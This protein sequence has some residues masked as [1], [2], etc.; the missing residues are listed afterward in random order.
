MT[1]IKHI[2]EILV[3][4]G[5]L[6]VSVPAQ[7]KARNLPDTSVTGAYVSEITTDWVKISVNVGTLTAEE[8]EAFEQNM[9]TNGSWEEIQELSEFACGLYDRE[10]VNLSTEYG[11]RPYISI[12]TYLFACAI[13]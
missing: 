4:S 8:V 12:I 9:V 11:G 1:K 6:L 13:D 10:S 5:V 3:L 2:V 7:S